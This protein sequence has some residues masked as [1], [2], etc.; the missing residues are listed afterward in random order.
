MSAD[1]DGGAAKSDW[2]N[3]PICGEPDMQSTADDGG[4]IIEC[5][6]LCC[7]SNGGD[8]KSAMKREQ[9][10]KPE[11]RSL[12]DWFAGQALAGL[13]ANYTM[14]ERISSRVASGDDSSRVAAS[15]CYQQADAML[16][17]RS[18]KKQGEE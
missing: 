6:N 1:K 14:L 10:P 8:N 7:A 15:I 12:R 17:A 4:Q 9:A 3:C 16:A 13:M 11:T 18:A 5:T 2:V